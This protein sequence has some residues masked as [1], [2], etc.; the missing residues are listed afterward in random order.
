MHVRLHHH[1][2]E[3]AVDAPATL[4]YGGEEAALAQLGDLQLDVAGLRGQQP[5]ARAV[6]LI[7][8]S[9]GAL[10]RP[11]PDV[12]GCLHFDERLQ[13]QLYA[14]PHDVDA[15]ARA[16][17]LQQ[18]GDVRLIQGHRVLLDV[19]LVVHTEDRPVAHLRVGPGFYTTP[20][21]INLD[22]RPSAARKVLPVLA[23]DA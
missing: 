9:R 10:K 18:L 7:R 6:A 12:A 19:C 20:W 21:Y 8:A 14:A 11:R 16:H 5:L 17:C 4:Q 1:R 13:H 15:A 22:T 3:R 2:E 23:S